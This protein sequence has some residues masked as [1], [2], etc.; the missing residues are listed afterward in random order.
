[1]KVAV[2]IWSPLRNSEVKSGVKFEDK[3]NLH[4]ILHVCDDG[5]LIFDPVKAKKGFY[6]HG[7][8][9]L[10][11]DITIANKHLPFKFDAIFEEGAGNRDVFER[12]MKPLVHSLMDGFDCSFINYG[13]TETGKTHT[14]IGSSLER[15]IAYLTMEYIFFQLK[16]RV[17]NGWIYEVKI[18]YLEVHNER[19]VNLLTK[20][21]PLTIVQ[22]GNEDVNILSLDMRKVNN[23]SEVHKLLTLGHRN[24]TRHFSKK[25]HSSQS[26]TI[27]QVHIN[28]P[29]KSLNGNN[30][31]NIVKLVVVELGGSERNATEATRSNSNDMANINKPILTFKNC[32]HRLSDGSKDIP[33]NDSSLTKI[34][35]KSLTCDALTVMLFNVSPSASNYN[36]TYNTLMYAKRAKQIGEPKGKENVK[37]IASNGNSGAG[38]KRNVSYTISTSIPAKNKST[39]TQCTAEIKSCKS[40]DDHKQK[41]VPPRSESSSDVTIELTELTRWYYEIN[42]IYDAVKTSVEGYCTSVSKEKLLELRLKCRN[43]VE[44]CRDLLT[45]TGCNRMTKV[46]VNTLLDEI[47]KQAAIVPNK[48]NYW[49]SR[50]QVC[51]KQLQNL[52]RK[53]KELKGSSLDHILESYISMKEFEVNATKA[54]QESMHIMKTNAIYVNKTE[55]YGYLSVLGVNFESSTMLHGACNERQ[56][57]SEL[58]EI[59]DIVL[60]QYADCLKASSQTKC[61]KV[62]SRM[63]MNL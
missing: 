18:S 29:C 41:N 5:N 28:T 38:L 63:S 23:L 26:N 37:E 33:F 36:D 50:I 11:R 56:H 8:K 57:C 10:H 9:Q 44:N 16:K 55:I 3:P 52:H 13:A 24:R 62:N 61:S 34:L 39:F 20:S 48:V 12:L 51:Q 42:T 4:S 60:P 6:Y 53:V 25:T 49:K 40:N 2:R 46:R 43:D 7:K 32:L 27:F 45:T 22:R 1:M 19:V 54:N 17:S 35:K 21:K 59:G 31:D 14:V 30:P 58:N 15:G 47:T